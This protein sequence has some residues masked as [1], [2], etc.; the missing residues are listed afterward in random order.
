[1]GRGG[2]GRRG[3]ED[4][5]GGRHA[6]G[7]GRLA[8][9]AC[10]LTVLKSRLRATSLHLAG[11]RPT[12]AGGSRLLS[13]GPVPRPG[14]EHKVETQDHEAPLSTLHP[15]RTPLTD[16]VPSPKLEPHG[17]PTLGSCVPLQG[18]AQALAALRHHGPVTQVVPS[19][20]AWLCHA[21]L[22][23]SV[24]WAVDLDRSTG[25]C[26]DHASVFPSVSWG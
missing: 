21:R 2:C 18:S 25:R 10:N 1:M 6:G 15:E 26:Q 20:M 24:V 22:W 3:Q 12:E 19:T 11:G 4:V 5:G 16:R 14:H 9:A 13:P 7:G 17:A 23:R 8:A